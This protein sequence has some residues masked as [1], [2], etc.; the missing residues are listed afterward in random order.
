MAFYSAPP[1]PQELLSV[2]ECVFQRLKFIGRNRCLACG[3]KLSGLL[4]CLFLI[5]LDDGFAKFLA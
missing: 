3:F 1:L 2:S 5:V 4:L